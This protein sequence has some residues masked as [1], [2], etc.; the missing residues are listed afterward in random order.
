[1]QETMSMNLFKNPAFSRVA[2]FVVFMA[3]IALEQGL[4]ALLERQVL[5]FEA[6]VLLWLYLPKAVLVGLMLWLLR[7]C[8]TEITTKDL[9]DYRQT[10]LSIFSGLLVFIFWINMDWTLGSQLAPAGFNPESFASEQA[11]WSMI[12]IRVTGAVII[13]PI[14]EELF[15]RSFLLR[16]L[17]DANF[18]AVT[19]GRFSLFSFLAVSVFF[20]LEHHYV[21]AGIMAGVFFNLIYYATKSIAQCILAHSVANLSLAA[22]VLLTQEWRFW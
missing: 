16:Y 20:G 2:P 14:M 4:R 3:F 13:V 1:M 21:F 15:W 18:T 7:Q 6:T 19:I 22:Y 12:F 5:H 10:A 9:R 17:I 11:K 8:Y